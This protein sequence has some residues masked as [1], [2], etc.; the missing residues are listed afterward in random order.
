MNLNPKKT[1][2]FICN[3]REKT[4]TFTKKNYLQ[5]I[6]KKISNYVTNNKSFTID[7]QFTFTESC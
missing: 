5:F 3:V 1:L 6:N 4:I 7:M 2:L